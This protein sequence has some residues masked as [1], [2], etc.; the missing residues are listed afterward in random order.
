[1]PV[2]PW[3][4]TRVFLSTNTAAVDDARAGPARCANEGRAA[5][6]AETPARSMAANNGVRFRVV[7]AYQILP[8][9]NH[10][11]ENLE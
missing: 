5:R 2:K 7:S 6:R 10:Y 9:R 3:Q 8:Q 1:M 11:W 4:M